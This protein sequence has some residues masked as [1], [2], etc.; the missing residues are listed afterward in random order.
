MSGSILSVPFSLL[1]AKSLGLN[2]QGESLQGESS[3][4]SP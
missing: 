3:Q 2:L 1:D 4:D